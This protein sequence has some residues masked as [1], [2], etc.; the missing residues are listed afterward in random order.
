[1]IRY[2][3]RHKAW[4]RKLTKPVYTPWAMIGIYLVLLRDKILYS[5]LIIS[6]T[7]YFGVLIKFSS[8]MGIRFFN[9]VCSGGPLLSKN[10]GN[11]PSFIRIPE[12]G[13]WLCVIWRINSEI[14]PHKDKLYGLI[15]VGDWTD[16]ITTCKTVQ[17]PYKS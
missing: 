9:L 12:R 6:T 14:F 7:H 16:Y 1:M 5:E 3:A 8:V 15:Q 17:W 13:I 4:V 2:G 11:Y 10:S